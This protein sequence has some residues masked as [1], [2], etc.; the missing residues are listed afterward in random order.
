M[1]WWDLPFGEI[2]P[3]G[4][5][6]VAILDTGIDATHPDLA[7]NVVPGTS[8]LDGS[9][10]LTD[11]NGHGTS[12]AGI[13]AARTNTVPAEGIA[14]VAYAGVR[15]MPVTVLNDQGLGQDSDVIAGVVWAADHGANV[16][17][18]GFSNTG[19]SQSLQDAI[20]YAWA[21]GVVLVAAVGNDAASTPTFPAGDRGVIGVSATDQ[22]DLLAAFS[23]DG[24]AV[25]LAA[26]GTDIQTTTV[27][28]GYGTVSGTSA[29]AAIVAGAAAML[30]A[31]DPTLANGVIVGRL[32]R[33]ADAAGTQEET[34]NGRVNMAHA[35]VDTG[36]DSVQPA[37]A[38]PVGAGGPFVGPYVSRG[39]F[40]VAEPHQRSG[41]DHSG[42]R[43]FGRQWGWR[44]F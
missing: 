8:I 29:A 39:G 30:K 34:G 12:L 15:V 20:D 43:E 19:F 32:A 3:T 2:T 36:T 6:N 41:L 42:E 4:L 18:M 21:N 27:G 25:F 31:V 1:I 7:S 9:D 11:P 10:G 16:I 40:V 35:L 37:G 33:T 28:G 13:V 5:A 24:Q 17:L 22:N 26:P 23:N 14:G 38:D 44:R